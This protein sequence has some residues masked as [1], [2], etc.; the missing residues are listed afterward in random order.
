MF[1]RRIFG[2]T[3]LRVDEFSSFQTDCNFDDRKIQIYV[4]LAVITL[5]T[6]TGSKS[7]RQSEAHRRKIVFFSAI[8]SIVCGTRRMSEGFCVFTEVE[9]QGPMLSFEIFSPKNGFKNW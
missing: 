4:Q 1:G 8:E 5:E 6:K 2:S 9:N 7:W 3:S